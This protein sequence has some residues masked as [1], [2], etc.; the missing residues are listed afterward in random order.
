M[1][2]WIDKLIT[3]FLSLWASLPDSTKN[4]MIEAI[5]ESFT[6]AF[7][8]FYKSTKNTGEKANG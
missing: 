3:W 5:V 4:K 7:R 8:S 2:S 1:T 6:E